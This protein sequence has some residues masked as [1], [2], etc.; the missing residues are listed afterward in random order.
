MSYALRYTL[1]EL[2]GVYT[3]HVGGA[4]GRFE[5]KGDSLD[6]IRQQLWMRH[7]DVRGP[8]P[9]QVDYNQNNRISFDPAQVSE[10]TFEL[11]S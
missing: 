10:L 6:A 9:V 4:G 1:R 7:K 11:D 8:A 2:G 5:L 3:L